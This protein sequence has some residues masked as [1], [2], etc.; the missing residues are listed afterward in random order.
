[1]FDCSPM[2]ADIQSINGARSWVALKGDNWLAY[3]NTGFG[4]PVNGA[5]YRILNLIYQEGSNN[6]L[7]A[8][9]C[10]DLASGAYCIYVQHR[11]LNAYISCNN[12]DVNSSGA[13][14]CNCN[15]QCVAGAKSAKSMAVSAWPVPT[16]NL[17]DEDEVA[18]PYWD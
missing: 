17:L 5:G 18:R 10:A 16:S 11:V 4:S 12:V 7:A 3:N 13:G 1:M 8:N 15:P 6:Q 9:T 14:F 2:Y